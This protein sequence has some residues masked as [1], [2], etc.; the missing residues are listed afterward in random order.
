VTES[1][2][3]HS[4]S[5]LGYIDYNSTTTTISGLSAGTQ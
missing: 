5:D 1:D 2:T 3:E 4:D